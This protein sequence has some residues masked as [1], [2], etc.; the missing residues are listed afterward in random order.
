MPSLGCPQTPAV[1]FVAPY[2]Y[3]LYVG[4]NAVHQRTIGWAVSSDGIAWTK[5]GPLV[6]DSMRAAWDS[7]VI[8][9]PTLLPTGANDGTFYVWFGGGDQRQ[10]A[11]NLDGQIGRMTVRFD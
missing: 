4:T 6:T 2:F 3:L 11:Q 5:R 8:C 9:D 1:A 10:D 7:Q